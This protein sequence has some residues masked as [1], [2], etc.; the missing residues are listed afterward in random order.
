MYYI[1]ESRRVNRACWHRPSTAFVHWLCPWPTFLMDTR[2]SPIFDYSLSWPPSNLSSIV[3]G[4][5]ACWKRRIKNGIWDPLT[6]SDSHVV[7]RKNNEKHQN[8]NEKKNTDQ[9]IFSRIISQKKYIV[10]F[11]FNVATFVDLTPVSRM[12]QK[13][14]WTAS[15][16]NYHFWWKRVP[17]VNDGKNKIIVRGNLLHQQNHNKDRGEG[18]CNTNPIIFS[19]A[20]QSN[21]LDAPLR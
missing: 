3:E 12:I 1:T 17:Y 2:R 10:S 5:S 16:E 6:S 20:F 11:L 13:R 14:W 4:G 18:L 7:K 9:N 21:K 19:N 15:S 8:R